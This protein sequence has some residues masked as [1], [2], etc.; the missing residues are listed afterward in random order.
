MN[1]TYLDDRRL[2]DVDDMLDRVTAEAKRRDEEGGELE[3]PLPYDP[4]QLHAARDIDGPSRG[5]WLRDQQDHDA[6][7]GD[8]DGPEEGA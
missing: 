8:P 3:E 4:E 7:S 1:V 5:Q 6:E 2:P